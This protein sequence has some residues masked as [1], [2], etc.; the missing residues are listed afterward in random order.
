MIQLLVIIAIVSTVAAYWV[1]R[2][3]ISKEG[4]MS[5][6]RWSWLIWGFTTIIEAATFYAVSKSMTQSIVLFV[7]TFACIVVALSVWNRQQWKRPTWTEIASVV[8]SIGAIGIWLLFKQD[9]WAHV[10]VIIAVPVSFLPTWA[11]LR[12]GES[13][14]VVMPWLLWTIGDALTLIVILI[15]LDDPKEIP[16]MV[17]ET[18]CHASVLLVAL[19]QRCKVV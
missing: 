3:E 13:K 16:Y 1:Y 8:M 6:N 4:D 11:T 2:N 18:I 7:S 10:L 12:T 15:T 19:K 17:V 5:P 9:W 14:E